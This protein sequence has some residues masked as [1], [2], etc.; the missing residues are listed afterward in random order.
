MPDQPSHALRFDLNVYAQTTE[1]IVDA[2]RELLMDFQCR[3][4]CNASQSEGIGYSYVY[5]LTEK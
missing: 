5:K 1:D 3:T 4:N 2:L